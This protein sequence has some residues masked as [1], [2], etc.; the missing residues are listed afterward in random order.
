MK[1]RKI[2]AI[3][4]IST[5]VIGAGRYFYNLKHPKIQYNTYKAAIGRL[6]QTVSE[7]GTIKKADELDLNFLAQGRIAKINVKVGDKVRKD[8]VLAELDYTNLKI[9]AKQAEAG[10]EIARANQLKA[11]NGASLQDVNVSQKSVDQAQNSYENALSDYNKLK[12]TTDTGIAQAEK[13]LAD[14]KN[15]GAKDSNLVVAL[16]TAQKNLASTLAANQQNIS[17]R[18]NSG[19]VTIHDKNIAAKTALDAVNRV[20]TDENARDTLSAGDSAQLISAKDSLKDGLDQYKV[21]DASYKSA[22]ASK[23]TGDVDKAFDDSEKLLSFTLS[24]LT[25]TFNALGKT[26]VT[27][28]F[29]QSALD[30]LKATI[31]SQLNAVNAAIAAIE[32]S[33]QALSDSILNASTAETSARQNLDTAQANY[34]NA[35]QTANN[36][37]DNSQLSQSQQLQSAKSKVDATY[38]ALQLAKAQFSKTTSSAR[39]EDLMLASAQVKQAQASLDTINN[40]ISN[41]QIKAPIDGQITK[42]NYKIGEAAVNPAIVLLGKDQYEIEL[43]IAESDII[44]IKIGQTADLTLDAF[45]DTAKFSSAVVS[46]D[47]AQTVIQEVV[48]YKTLLSDILPISSSSEEQMKLI[49][50]GMTA[51]ATILTNEKNGIIAIPNRA[52]IEKADGSKFV[53]VLKDGNATE[54]PVTIGLK[55]DEGMTEI[56]GGI[57]PGDEIIINTKSGS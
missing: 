31:S 40:Q 55:G 12:L 15:T 22:Y 19:L 14:L 53:R 48:Y 17:N 36:A 21:A 49:K 8:Q 54:T 13:N 6:S 9:Q 27:M 41:S 10:V 23:N 37:L 38:D 39:P 7:T 57:N 11:L 44:K 51:N 50:P 42:I 33:H 47:P 52:I 4:A 18:T 5:I 2:I 16:A 28:S 46:I 20:I 30:A 3:I 29:P 45:G 35:L 24:A 43:D 25:S 34:D 1:K 32:G 26:A 56:L